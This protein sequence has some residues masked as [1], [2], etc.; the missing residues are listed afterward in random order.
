MDV[1]MDLEAEVILQGD[2]RAFPA[3]EACPRKKSYAVR[4]QRNT[5]ARQT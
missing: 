2:A 4:K 1:A 5:R 3:N